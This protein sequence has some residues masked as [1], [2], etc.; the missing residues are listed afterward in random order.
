MAHGWNSVAI[1]ELCERVTSGG[2]PKRSQSAYYA[3][4]GSGHAWVKSSELR[5]RYVRSSKERISNLGLR[6]SAAKLL[7]PDTV[8]VAMYGATAGKVGLLKAEAAVNQAVCALLPDRSRADP[9]FLFHALRS[10]Y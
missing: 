4:N 9:V 8:L 3:S 10:Q 7:P 6:E 2:T 5:D 1:E